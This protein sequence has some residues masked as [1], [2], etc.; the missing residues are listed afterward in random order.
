MDDLFEFADQSDREEL[1]KHVEPLI[2]R[3]AE[4]LQEV[5][6][7]EDQFQV[8]C[9]MD[10]GAILPRRGNFKP[11]SRIISSVIREDEDIEEIKELERFLGEERG[12]TPQRQFIPN[13]LKD[14]LGEHGEHTDNLDE[15]IDKVVSR[16]EADIAGL[17][18]V[19]ARIPLRGL[20]AG[21]DIKLKDN[22]WLRSP[23]SEVLFKKRAN[24]MLGS[25]GLGVEH[26]SSKLE[27]ETVEDGSTVNKDVASTRETLLTALRVY[28]RANVS[29]IAQ[30]R[31]PV[32]YTSIG[33]HQT[34][35]IVKSGHPKYKFT[36]IDKPRFSNLV[37]LLTQFYNIEDRSFNSP[38]GIPL[39]H[40]EESL[41]R[42]STP[43]RSI[44]FSI[45][46]LESLY[47]TCTEGKSKTNDIKRYCGLVL[48]EVSEEFGP[49]EVKSDLDRAYEFRNTWA[50]G[51]KH[52]A[53]EEKLTQ[54]SL[55]DYL[56]ASIVT[57]AWLEAEGQLTQGALEIEKAL[58][59][60]DHRSALQ[61]K[62]DDF[63][64]ID[65]LPI[66]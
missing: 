7:E 61:N 51:D 48:S 1:R 52:S 25:K 58:I 13:L 53:E 29:Y 60:E 59:D 31:E 23:R 39:N 5:K 42:R 54:E 37:R 18:R 27:I 33:M 26:A 49:L 46:G 20:E 55:W 12:F 50:H 15:R 57:F 56:R 32:T 47:R 34:P 63:A 6:I 19:R 65:Y 4:D 10:D 66:R 28:G 17:P 8:W 38:I 35:N 9:W 62:L 43:Q 22:I 11:V 16:I 2:R 41:G 3:F 36:P 64:T 30:I 24:S 45:I 44:S 14:A 21:C 40:Y